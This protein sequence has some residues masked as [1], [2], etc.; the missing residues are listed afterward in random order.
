MKYCL[1]FVFLWAALSWAAW[2]DDLHGNVW[3][4]R[5]HNSEHE[6]AKAEK[7]ALMLLE[8]KDPRIPY[9]EKQLLLHLYFAQQRL[10]KFVDAERSYKSFLVS[11][12]SE[13][14]MNLTLQMFE[15]RRQLG[16]PIADLQ[17]I[18]PESRESLEVGRVNPDSLERCLT[19]LRNSGTDSLIVLRDGKPVFLWKSRFYR[20]SMATMSSV[21]S[22]AALL[23]GIAVE[24]GLLTTKTRV[25]DVLPC[26]NEGFRAEVDVESLLTMSSGLLRMEKGLGL[27]DRGS[28]LN[29]WVQSLTPQI[30]AGTQ[31]A[32]SNEGAQLLAPVL[33]ASTG[34]PVEKFAEKYLF[35]PLGLRKTK[36]LMM[37]QDASLYADAETT[38]EE[39]AKIGQL[40]LDR[41]KGPDGLEIVSER[42]IE[43]M[44]M[45][46]QLNKGYGYL[47]WLFPDLG[48]VAMQGYLGTSCWIQAD[49]KLVIARSQQVV[50]L[51]ASQT[52]DIRDWM[53]L[54]RGLE[55]P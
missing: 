28:S 9:F 39:F 55:P 3:T 10:G 26:W 46:C 22:V 47:W 5:R 41:G 34:Q 30:R 12:G 38:I 23:V 7:L 54:Y 40:V 2:G 15:L 14:D 8:S 48:M 4:V 1:I 18:L 27:V 51:H 13:Q 45:P 42:W 31:W 33:E 44:L 16:S 6:Y 49:Q 32:Y 24:K 36:L 43:E 19:Y 29:S 20:G 50:Y 17:K 53:D 25:G 21:K 52:F 35:A 37:D 11:S